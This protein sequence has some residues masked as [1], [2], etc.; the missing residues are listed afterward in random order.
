MTK[1]Q[2]AELYDGLKGVIYMVYQMTKD[3]WLWHMWGK[4]V[5]A[6]NETVNLDKGWEDQV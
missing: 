1:F 5:E 4:V 2:K 3:D 6:Y